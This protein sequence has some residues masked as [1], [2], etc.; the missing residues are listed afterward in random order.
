MAEGRYTNAHSIGLMTFCHAQGSV[1]TIYN[2]LMPW[3]LPHANCSMPCAQQDW[4]NIILYS[5]CYTLLLLPY[6]VGFMLT[7]SNHLSESV[8]WI[9]QTYLRWLVTGR[10]YRFLLLLSHNSCTMLQQLGM[11]TLTNICSQVCVVLSFFFFFLHHITLDHPSQT[12]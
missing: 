11:D 6:Y 7:D 4:K 8:V 2:D 5:I 3:T 10:W 1:L 12:F 9:S